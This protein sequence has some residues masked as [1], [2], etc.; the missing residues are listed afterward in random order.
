MS[1]LSE[2]LR[3]QQTKKIDERIM[4]KEERSE[5][6]DELIQ[7]LQDDIELCFYYIEKEYDDIDYGDAEIRYGIKSVGD[8]I[9]LVEKFKVKAR[10]LLE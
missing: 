1:D 2:F 9:N 10:E 3:W 8:I 6:Y 7:E 4:N 5:A